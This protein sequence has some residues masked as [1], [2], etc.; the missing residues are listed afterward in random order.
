MRCWVLGGC[1][2]VVLA[3]GCVSRDPA[4][5]ARDPIVVERAADGGALQRALQAH[6]WT[7][8]SATDAQGRRVE[9]LLPGTG[10]PV[11]FGFDDSRLN[12]EGGCNRLFGNYRVDGQRLE[13]ARLA[14]TRM[15]C[16]PAAMRVDSM[17]GELLAPSSIAELT[18]G[19]A[20]SLRLVLPSGVT[21]GLAGRPTNRALYGTPTRVFLEVAAQTVP[22]ARP[23]AGASACLQVRERRYDDQG[24][25]VGA[26]GEW[27][28]FADGIEGYTHR[29]GVRNV[30]R[31]ER[32]D[33]GAAGGTAGGTT[34]G[35]SFVYV[36][37]LVVE[38]QAM[39]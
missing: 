32:F 12:V 38:S 11:V 14:S 2:F 24:R 1:A 29:P 27:Q 13:V 37:D 18:A 3:T 26:A 36:L 33:R 4:V 9:A 25:L 20:P 22:C 17:L 21:L 35:A 34:S 7:L 30:L 8:V 31:V 5:A 19:D 28:T 10:R 23:P 39:P 6:R 16:E 15:A